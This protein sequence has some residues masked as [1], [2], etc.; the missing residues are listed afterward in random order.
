M[1][2]DG[3]GCDYAVAEVQLPRRQNQAE[4]RFLDRECVNSVSLKKYEMI[5]RQ[6]F[7][8]WLL[9]FNYSKRSA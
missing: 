8:D 6:L 1:V 9:N 4:T 2:V 3:G 5:A 7:Q